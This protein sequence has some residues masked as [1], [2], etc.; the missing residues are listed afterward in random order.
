MFK[1]RKESLIYIDEDEKMAIVDA[2]EYKYIMEH[3]DR[4]YVSGKV[5]SKEYFTEE[6]I[7]RFKGK[8][9]QVALTLLDMVGE[10]VT[11]SAPVKEQTGPLC[12]V[13][14]RFVVMIGPREVED[15][16]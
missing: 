2:S 8:H 6:C 3:E 15:E 13:G 10:I 5:L 1:I 14:K 7:D 4:E 16:M 12:I 11:F 9:V